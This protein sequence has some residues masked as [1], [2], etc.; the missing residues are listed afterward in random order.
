M[1]EVKLAWINEEIASLK[2]DPDF[3]Q[4][5]DMNSLFLRSLECDKK[6]YEHLIY[7]KLHP[8]FISIGDRKIQLHLAL[9][10]IRDSFEFEPEGEFPAFSD[11]IN[12]TG[13]DTP[14]KVQEYFA[15]S[16]K[17]K[18]QSLPYKP[19]PDSNHSRMESIFTEEE[20]LSH[21]EDWRILVS[22]GEHIR[23]NYGNF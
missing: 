10:K 14:S 12:L 13:F 23:K 6:L 1:E 16:A 7:H 22:K 20:W 5:E 8:P 11:V 15:Q 9:S 21:L 18:S 17:M 3:F 19:K 4:N 2:N